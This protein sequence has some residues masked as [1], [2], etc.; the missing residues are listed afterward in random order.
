[1]E[2]NQKEEKNLNQWE[3]AV[4]ENPNGGHFRQNAYGNSPKA[5]RC[6]LIVSYIK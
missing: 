5:C 6:L 4:W 1:M 3:E 2:K